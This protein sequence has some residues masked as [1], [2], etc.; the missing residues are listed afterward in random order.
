MAVYT[1]LNVQVLGVFMFV[2]NKSPGNFGP[3]ANLFSGAM[4]PVPSPKGAGNGQTYPAGACHT[5]H[6]SGTSHSTWSVCTTQA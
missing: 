1:L 2:L 5:S 4:Y 3:W 6:T